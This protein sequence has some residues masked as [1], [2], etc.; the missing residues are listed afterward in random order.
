VLKQLVGKLFGYDAEIRELRHQIKELSWDSTFGMWT[1]GAFLKFCHVMPRDTRCL[2]FI[3]LNKIHELNEKYG[4]SEVDRRVKETF[5]VP[6]R[7]SDVVA[8]WYP[9]DEIVIL[10]DSDI[11]VAEGKIEQLHESAADQDLTFY[12]AVGQ[13]EV[14]K[15]PIEEVVDELALQVVV[16]KGQGVRRCS[17]KPLSMC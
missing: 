15:V 2:A 5:S 11:G 4:Y 3:D 6:F 9:G 12:V 14:G 17:Y 13:W 8:R 1:R 16:Q 10:F 7:R